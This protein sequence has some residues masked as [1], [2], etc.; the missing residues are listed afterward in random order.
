MRYISPALAYVWLSSRRGEARG[1]FKMILG[2]PR[3]EVTFIV[4]LENIAPRPEDLQ[5]ILGQ[6]ALSAFDKRFA[7]VD[8]L[9]FIRQ[10]ILRSG[11]ETTGY[12]RRVRAGG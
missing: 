10:A 1:Q 7:D 5:A 12:S 4:A 2:L 8:A 11:P 3:N 9:P 6:D